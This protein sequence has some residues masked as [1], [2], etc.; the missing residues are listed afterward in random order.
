MQFEWDPSKN[1]TNQKKHKVSFEEAKTVFYDEDAIMFD[2]PDHSDDEEEKFL[3]LGFS[4]KAR[5]LLVCHCFR[6]QDRIIRIISARKA[7]TEEKMTY[8]EMKRGW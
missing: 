4:S 3:M 1:D 8:D 7:T 6:A 5:I 2:D